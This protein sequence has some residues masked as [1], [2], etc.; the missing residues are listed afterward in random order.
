MGINYY[1]TRNRKNIEILDSMLEELPAF[2]REYF[3]GK[4]NTTT[5]MTRRNYAYDLRI[6][7]D[8]LSK[9]VYKTK[10]IKDITLNDLDTLSTT[11]LE[12]Y[13][14]Y[15]NYYELNGKH[16]PTTSAPK[17]GNWL[18]CAQCTNIFSTKTS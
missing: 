5:S 7:F 17:P 18:Q 9:K 6:F 13:L 4:E 15:L 2:C 12:R 16:Y 8:F 11:D 1:E 3:L 14:S 10:E